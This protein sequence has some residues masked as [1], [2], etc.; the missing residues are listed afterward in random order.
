MSRELAGKIRGHVENLVQSAEQLEEQDQEDLKDQSDEEERQEVKDV[1]ELIEQLESNL[2]KVDENLEQMI[3]NDTILFEENILG[4][5]TQTLKI[6]E[7]Q[8]VLLLHMAKMANKDYQIGKKETAKRKASRCLSDFELL[9]GLLEISLDLV[10]DEME[11]SKIGP[12]EDEELRPKMKE[13]KQELRSELREVQKIENKINSRLD[14][15]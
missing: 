6:S 11:M 10:E 1:S 4:I 7:A 2:A 8:K 15:F 13:Q 3:E 14:W 5:S 12:Q 9:K